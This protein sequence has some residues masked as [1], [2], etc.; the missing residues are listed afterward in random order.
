MDCR[1][2]TKTQALVAV[3]T[4]GKEALWRRIVKFQFC[5]MLT[6][7]FVTAILTRIRIRMGLH[8]FGSPDRYLYPPEVE[9]W[10]RIRNT[11]QSIS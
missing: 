2:H 9:S 5:Q 1:R 8:W 11:A 10:I 6:Q 3:H 7:L 4:V